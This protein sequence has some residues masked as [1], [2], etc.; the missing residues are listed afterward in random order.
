MIQKK[1]S[2]KRL[3][4]SKSHKR[5]RKV[6]AYPSLTDYARLALISILREFA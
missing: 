3:L 2:R 1:N 5:S 6:G 4:K